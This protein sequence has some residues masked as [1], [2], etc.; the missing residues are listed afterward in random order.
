MAYIYNYGICLP[1]LGWSVWDI[2]C[3][4][5][6]WEPRETR[7]GGSNTEAARDFE[8]PRTQLAN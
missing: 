2:R 3:W 1:T 5:W 6:V 7:T 8:K 4:N